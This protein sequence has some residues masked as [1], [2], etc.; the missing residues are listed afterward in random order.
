ME[1]FIGGATAGTLATTVTY[2]LDLLRTR[3]A[4]QGTER[5]YTG[6]RASI[7]DIALREG[8]KGF[9][10]GLAATLVGIA[11]NSGLV[12]AS[13]EA[14]KHA[15]AKLSLPFGSGDAMA[16]GAAAILAKTT[17][18]PLDT[19]RKRLQVQGPMLAKYG[20]GN[21]PLYAGIRGAFDTI[22]K[23]EGIRGYYRGLPI[24]LIKTS[25]TSAI[26]F[27]VY[28]R[29]MKFLETFED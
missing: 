27:W 5:V 17:F 12:F 9:Y 19:I 28:G 16:G 22:W 7:R 25:P 24:S 10:R 1:Q 11:P 3:F 21:I 6:I 29:T 2:P 23:R 18:Y 4:A 8:P 13:N 20:R 26:T 14:F 15:F